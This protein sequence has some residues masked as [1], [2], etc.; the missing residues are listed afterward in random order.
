MTRPKK[1]GDDTANRAVWVVEVDFRG[2][3]GW[4]ACSAATIGRGTSGKLL[5]REWRKNIAGASLRLT[6]YV[7]AKP[8]RKRGR[9][10]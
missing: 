10:K 1:H 9:V 7:P 6:R 4:E 3:R 8:R 2:G 5:L